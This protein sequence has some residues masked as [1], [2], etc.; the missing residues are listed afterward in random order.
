MY[1]HRIN[2]REP[3]QKK[4][5][6]EFLYSRAFHW[7]NKLMPFE[8][9]WL[10]VGTVFAP[11]RVMLNQQVIGEQQRSRV[12]LEGTITKQIQSQNLLQIECLQPPT[13]D[14]VRQ[15]YLEVRRTVHLRN[16]IGSTL[17]EQDQLRLKLQ[18]DVHG[19]PDR[20]LSLVIRLDHQEVHYQELG[21]PTG[22]LEIITPPLNVKPWQANQPNTLHDLE[23]QLLDPACSLSQHHYLTAFAQPIEATN[24]EVFPASEGYVASQSLEQADRN[25]KHFILEDYHQVLP[26][27]WHHPCVRPRSG[28]VTALPPEDLRCF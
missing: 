6:T 25:G 27:V 24:I 8:E 7:P 3:W 17:W 28:P 5:P 26:W 16:I 9:L 2:L 23:V 13:H 20:P 22:P 18:A 11:F 4:S 12:P 1:P 10:M 15:V 14:L 21:K 19:T